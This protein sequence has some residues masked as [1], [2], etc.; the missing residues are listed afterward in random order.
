MQ[1]VSDAL[2]CVNVQQ[3]FA[4]ASVQSLAV[5]H[6]WTLLVSEHV[7]AKCVAHAAA[8]VH[9]A[10]SDAIPHCGYAPVPSNTSTPQHTGVVPP[11]PPG[12]SHVI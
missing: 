6:S 8:D 7:S 11:Q 10:P 12:P 1:N 9:D 2:P 3:W 5:W 4:D